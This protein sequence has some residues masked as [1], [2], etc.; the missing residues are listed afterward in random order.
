M[1]KRYDEP[2]EVTPGGD[3]ASGAPVAFSWRGRRYDV[4]RWLKT[5]R[6]G[7]QWWDGAEVDEREYHRVLARPA[8]AL[9]SGDLDADGFLCSSGAVYD[10]YR[11]RLRGGWRLARVWD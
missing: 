2:I 11:D 7:G 5:W 9:A 3:G 8:G 6:A 10:L 4:D 1:T